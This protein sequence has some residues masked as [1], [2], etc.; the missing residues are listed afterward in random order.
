[1]RPRIRPKKLGVKWLFE[2]FEYEA[3][4]VVGDRP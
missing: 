3:T 4:A 2:Q 1:M